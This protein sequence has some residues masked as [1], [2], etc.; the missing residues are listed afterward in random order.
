MTSTPN[1][2]TLASARRWR[3]TRD[4]GDGCEAGDPIVRGR[5]GH[6][7]DNRPGQCGVTIMA[8]VGIW[9][10]ARRQGLPYGFTL[11][12]NGDAEGSMLFD[13]ADRTQV[14]LAARL[15]GVRSKRQPSPSQLAAFAAMR[16]R[17]QSVSVPRREGVS[18]LQNRSNLPEGPSVQGAPRRAPNRSRIGG[19]P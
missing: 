1:L 18:S 16:A 12:Q 19:S 13:P 11:N 14:T 5:R 15:A 2:T 3:L 9:N 10:S 8:T 4:P 6:L 17:R 7:W